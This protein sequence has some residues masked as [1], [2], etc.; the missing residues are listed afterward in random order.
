MRSLVCQRKLFLAV[1]CCAAGSGGCVPD[2]PQP[3]PRPRPIAV[4][5]PSGMSAKTLVLTA[6][7]VPSDSS[8]NGYADTFQVIIYIFGDRNRHELPIHVDGTMIFELTAASGETL[9]RWSLDEQQVRDGQ[10]EALVGPGYGFTLNIL[11][12]ATDRTENRLAD[13]RAVFIPVQGQ[14][15][16]TRGAATIRVGR[17][18]L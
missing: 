11:D 5:Q 3:P 15:I 12:V 10:F 14:P 6:D 13:L 9:A 2:G 7:Q 16:E 18:G 8:G 17:V 4:P 1:L